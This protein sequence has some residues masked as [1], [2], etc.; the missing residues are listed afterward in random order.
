[1]KEKFLELRKETPADLEK[2]WKKVHVMETL[3]LN[4]RVSNISS[5]EEAKEIAKNKGLDVINIIKK[6]DPK[7][8]NFS[9]K[10]NTVVAVYFP[11]RKFLSYSEPPKYKYDTPEFQEFTQRL[12]KKRF[13][14]RPILLNTTVRRYTEGK[15]PIHAGGF[16]GGVY[17][18]GAEIILDRVFKTGEP[19]TKVILTHEL[20]HKRRDIDK[21]ERE[22]EIDV[23]EIETELETIQRGGI[24]DN[25]Y[26]DYA[27][28]WNM[29]G[30]NW[31]KNQKQDY[32]TL[33]GRKAPKRYDALEIPVTDSIAGNIDTRKTITNLWDVIR[34]NKLKE[35]REMEV[36]REIKGRGS[37]PENIDTSFI[38]SEGDKYHFFSPSGRAKPRQI[39]KFI[40][41]ADGMTGE[42]DIWQIMDVG[43]RLLIS[44]KATPNR[45]VKK[46]KHYKKKKLKKNLMND[47]LGFKFF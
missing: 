22:T 26:T 17:D 28:Y 44:D 47:I 15:M 40:D 29:L 35:E 42:E 20:T 46:Q 36:E 18:F 16:T 13:P 41:R 24:I 7:R 32:R 33:T 45:V 21:K 9:D 23:E 19:D 5:L 43:K 11:E 31:R 39:A 14:D 10:H 1:M 38:T 6:E 2:V 8:F 37:D 12:I 30:R 3:S 4:K 27:G 34:S 25:R